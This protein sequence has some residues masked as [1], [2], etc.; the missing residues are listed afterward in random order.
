MSKKPA[1]IAGFLLAVPF[2][3]SAVKLIE[4]F[5]PLSLHN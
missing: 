4:P 2:G 3:S 1:S 5:L